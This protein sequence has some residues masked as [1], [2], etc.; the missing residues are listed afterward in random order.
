MILDNELLFVIDGDNIFRQGQKYYGEDCRVSYKKLK[1]WVR[2]DRPPEMKYHMVVFMTLKAGVNSQLK[3]VARLDYLGFET[4]TFLSKYDE[5][6][7]LVERTSTADA[8]ITY[9]KNFRCQGDHYPKTV[10]V[11]SA[12]GE[13]ADLYTGLSFLGVSVEVM[14]V[15]VLSKR[16]QDVDK[17]IIIAP[18]MFFTPA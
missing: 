5:A 1:E 15:D 2:Q 7:G 6:T 16:V 17:R 13:F 8:I 18:E 4:K 11:A 10:V 14:Y 9:I 3:F 12:S